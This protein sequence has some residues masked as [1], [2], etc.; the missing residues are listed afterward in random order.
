VLAVVA[1]LLAT[2]TILV[3]CGSG[4]SSGRTSVPKTTSTATG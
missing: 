2:T 1:A 4:S 3:G